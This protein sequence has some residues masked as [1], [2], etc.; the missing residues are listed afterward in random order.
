MW[1]WMS[2]WSLEMIVR[3]SELV[4]KGCCRSL[5]TRSGG[6]S[7]LPTIVVIGV[8]YQGW[9]SEHVTNDNCCQSWSSVGGV[10]ENIGGWKRE[11]K[12]KC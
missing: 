2:R 9:S 11:K 8:G 4:A 3:D 1:S 5:A 6:R 12:G 10:I 7:V